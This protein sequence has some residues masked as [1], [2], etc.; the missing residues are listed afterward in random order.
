[1]II[2]EEFSKTNAT[3]EDIVNFIADIVC[4]RAKNG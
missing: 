3:L 4:E 1:V 2:S